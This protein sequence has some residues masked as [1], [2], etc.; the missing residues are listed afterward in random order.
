MFIYVDP[1]KLVLSTENDQERLALTVLASHVK[2]GLPPLQIP[3]EAPPEAVYTL[4]S[5]TSAISRTMPNGNSLTLL[6]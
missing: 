1:T 5:T 6:P 3:P 2:L 4:P